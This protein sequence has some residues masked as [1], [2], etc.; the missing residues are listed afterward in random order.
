[1]NSSAIIV[2]PPLLVFVPKKTAHVNAHISSIVPNEQDI[3]TVSDFCD[4]K[5]HFSL[6][7]TT[8]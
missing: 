4:K 2:Q 8:Y 7:K 6:G 3:K 5:L 1:M